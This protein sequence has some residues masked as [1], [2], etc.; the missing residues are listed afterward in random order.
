MDWKRKLNRYVAEATPVIQ[1]DTTLKPC[2]F[3]LNIF[4]DFVFTYQ[5]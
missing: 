3:A 5:R 1:S 4:K 2:N